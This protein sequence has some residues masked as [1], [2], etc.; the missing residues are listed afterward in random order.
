MGKTFTQNK[1]LF[2]DLRHIRC[3]DL[4]WFS[5]DGNYLTTFNPPG[6]PTSAYSEPAFVPHGIRL[7]SNVS[8]RE[9]IPGPSKTL[10]RIIF[11]QGRYR[12]WYLET[13]PSA[14]CYTES[15]DGFNWSSPRRS[16]LQI[17]GTPSHEFCLL[18]TSPSPRDRGCYRMPSSA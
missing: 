16:P 11:D 5:G 2:T 12:S 17:Q 14:I 18:Y 4:E 8:K 13:R 1:Y 7:Q 6:P 3:G 9:L 15:S 10:G